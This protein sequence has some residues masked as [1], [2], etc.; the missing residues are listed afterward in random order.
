M[1]KLYCLIL[2]LSLGHQ[3]LASAM[4]QQLNKTD[5]DSILAIRQSAYDLIDTINHHLEHRDDA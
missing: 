5:R 3:S 1:Y 4:Q 2:D